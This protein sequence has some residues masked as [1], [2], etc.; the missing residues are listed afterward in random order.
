MGVGVAVGV[1]VGVLVACAVL[2]GVAVAVGNGVALGAGVGVGADAGAQAD[3]IRL[4]SKN[5]SQ[6]AFH[7]S[8]SPVAVK[9]PNGMRFSRRER[10]QRAKRRRLEAHVGR[11]L[12]K[13]LFRFF[14]I[15]VN[16][17]LDSFGEEHIV[18]DGRDQVFTNVYS[19]MPYR[20]FRFI[21]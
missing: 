13:A 9:P 4:T 16:R 15:L 21:P 7:S 20:L 3:K 2:V 19:I 1:A 18:N 12:S 5:T 14:A 8:R 6:R 17:K 10:A 11:L